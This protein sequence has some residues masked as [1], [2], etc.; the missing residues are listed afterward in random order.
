MPSIMTIA[1]VCRL[2]KTRA[3]IIIIYKGELWMSIKRVKEHMQFSLEY[4]KCDTAPTNI[5]F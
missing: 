4:K 2:W 3:N 1:D 5:L